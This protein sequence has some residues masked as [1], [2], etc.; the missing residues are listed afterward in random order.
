MSISPEA[1]LPADRPLRRDA[2]RNRDTLLAVAGAQFAEQ[3]LNAPLE[4]VAK[5]AHVAI[6]TLYRHFPT[7]VDLIQAVFADKLHIWLDA[8]ERAVA[9]A[10]AW[11]GFELFAETMC[12]LQADDRGFADLACVRLPASNW[13]EGVQSRIH[14]LGVQIVHRAQAQESMRADVNAQ[15]LAFVVWSHSR[16]TEAT[17]GIA[18][19]AWR[20]HLHLM[21]DAFRADKTHPLPEPPMTPEQV[22]G[23]MVRLGGDRI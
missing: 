10:D 5:Q 20:R 11:Q 13:I 9:M 16:I 17:R 22:Y 8:A 2:Q 23:A 4:Q 18:P 6:G 7:R 3:G 1:S 21:L 15:D 12:E 19:A 14:D